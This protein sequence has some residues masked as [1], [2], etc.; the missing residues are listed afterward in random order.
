MNEEE[1]ARL[2][3]AYRRGLAADILQFQDA[4]GAWGVLWTV[5]PC[6]PTA[7]ERAARQVARCRP[8]RVRHV[9]RGRLTRQIGESIDVVIVTEAFPVIQTARCL[10]AGRLL[11]IGALV[12][13]QGLDALMAIVTLQSNSGVNGEKPIVEIG[14]RATTT[15]I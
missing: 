2:L 12:S 6:S 7:L 10:Q 8:F 4:A 15:R 11:Q 14:R 13:D 5:P 3:T 1:W 9:R